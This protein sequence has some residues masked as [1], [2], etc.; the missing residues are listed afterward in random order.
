VKGWVLVSDGGTGGSR[1]CLVAARGLAAGGYRVAVTVSHPTRLHPPSRFCTRRIEVPAAWE[2]G[3]AEAVREAMAAGG[4]V[5]LIPASE[6]AM[7][8]LGMGLA[9]VADKATLEGAAEAAGIPVPPS[10]RFA[11]AAEAVAAAPELSYPCVVKPAERR[12]HAFRADSPEGL[13][14]RLADEGAVVVQPYLAQGLR[15]VAGVMWKGEMVAAEHE[16]WLRIWPRDCG[17]A[18]AAVTTAPDRDLERRLTTLMDGYDGLFCAQLAGDQLFDLNLRIHSSHSLA[19]AAGVNLVAILCD[20]TTGRSVPEV[21][22]RPGYFYRWLEADI[23]SVVGGLRSRDLSPGAALRA[24]A[25][26]P[27]AAHSTESL[28]DPGP[29]AARLVYALGRARMSPDR[30]R[31]EPKGMKMAREEVVEGA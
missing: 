31:G 3:Y 28:R 2:P 12:Y 30:R 20:L 22:A 29:L 4:Y 1:D 18:S 23:R 9:R 14:A 13:V 24:L 15:A 7:V 19:V 8:A 11:S 17:L 27:G 16:R 25:P 10:R 21:R 26:H 5:A 6:E